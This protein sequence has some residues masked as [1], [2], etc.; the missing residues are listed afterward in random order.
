MKTPITYE[1]KFEECVEDGRLFVPELAP[2][3]YVGGY[4][5]H[6]GGKYGHEF[7]TIEYRL[8]KFTYCAEDK[9]TCESEW[10]GFEVGGSVSPKAIYKC[11]HGIYSFGIVSANKN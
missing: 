5:H 10:F 11:K 9:K 2:I 8:A 1:R 7:H 3:R 4:A 6:W